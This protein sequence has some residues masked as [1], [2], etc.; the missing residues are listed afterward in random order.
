MG[1]PKEKHATPAPAWLSACVESF[2]SLQRNLFSRRL[3]AHASLQLC[4]CCFGIFAARHFLFFHLLFRFPS[5]H[6][7]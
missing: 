1:A 4:C 6:L 5:G 2:Q 3:T 7:L